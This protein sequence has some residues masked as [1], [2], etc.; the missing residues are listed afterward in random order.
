[1]T[2][3]ELLAKAE[4]ELSGETLLRLAHRKLEQEARATDYFTRPP[5]FTPPT[6][7]QF[8]AYLRKLRRTYGVSQ[9]EL[10]TYAEVTSSA[11]QWYE[12]GRCLPHVK[13]LG[14][15]GKLFGIPYTALLLRAAAYSPIVA[16]PRDTPK[17]NSARSQNSR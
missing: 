15:I 12:Y 8:G 2:H 1:M 9:L 16:V 3:E 17:N 4:S 5:I 6:A 14:F 11:V 13:T 10:A 7:A